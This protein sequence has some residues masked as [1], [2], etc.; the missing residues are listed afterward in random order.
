MNTPDEAVGLASHCGPLLLE[1]GECEGNGGAAPRWQ[2]LRR[3]GQALEALA[4]GGGV[5][6]ALAPAAAKQPGQCLS[7]C[8]AAL[9]VLELALDAAAAEATEAAAAAVAAAAAQQ[10]QQCAPGEA[11][12]GLELPMSEDPAAAAATVA[13]AAAAAAAE[14]RLQEDILRVL[15]KAEAAA[16]LLVRAE[17]AAS[18]PAPALG[19]EGA[20]GEAL[21]DPWEL[22]YQLALSLGKEAAVDEL[23]GNQ[24]R[25]LQLYAQASAGP[26]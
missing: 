18:G 7:L 9:Q 17:G 12:A 15:H 22:C 14:A 11:G 5:G 26:G 16:A 23:L 8:T 2:Q 4:G 1:E 19:E 10:Q 20:G 13:A 25:S 6:P 3:A 24:E 21:P